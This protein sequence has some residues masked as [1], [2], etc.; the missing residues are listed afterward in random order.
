MFIFDWPLWGLAATYFVLSFA[1]QRV[2]NRLPLFCSLFWPFISVWGITWTIIG[3]ALTADY[4]WL[5]STLW[6]HVGRLTIIFLAALPGQWVAYRNQTRILIQIFKQ[7]KI[8]KRT[9]GYTIFFREL[10]D[11]DEDTENDS[12]FYSLPAHAGN[13]YCRVETSRG[14]INSYRRRYPN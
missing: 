4:F 6:Q 11:N 9:T 8:S 2:I 13:G 10:F 7:A 1:M 5:D 14:R 3:Y 12:D